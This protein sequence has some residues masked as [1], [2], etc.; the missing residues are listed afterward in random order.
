MVQSAGTALCHF[1]PCAVSWTHFYIKEGAEPVHHHE[2]LLHPIPL[3]TLTPTI[4]WQPLIS[5]PSLY[6]CHFKN[7]FCV[8]SYHTVSPLDICFLPQLNANKMP[9]RS[10]QVVACIKKVSLLHMNLQVANFQICKRVFT[11]PTTEVSRMS[12]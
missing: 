4:P 3:A 10:I 9:M 2:D 1:I 8:R 12:G 11:Y 6:F 5:F 7:V